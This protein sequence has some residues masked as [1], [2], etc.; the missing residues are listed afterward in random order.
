MYDRSENK[1]KNVHTSIFSEQRIHITI[2]LRSFTWR[3]Q[4]YKGVVVGMVVEI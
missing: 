1:L 4:V 3:T 2:V